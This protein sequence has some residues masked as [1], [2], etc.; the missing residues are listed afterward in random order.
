MEKVRDNYN[1][2]VQ[3]IKDIK[4]YGSSQIQAVREQYFEQVTTLSMYYIVNLLNFDPPPHP[5][6]RSSS[7]QM[8]RIRDYSSSQLDRVHENYIF[9]RQR[10]RKFSAQNYLRVRAT[11][12]STQ[13]TLN[14][15][16]EHLPPLYLDL[17]NCRQGMGG[18]QESMHFPDFQACEVYFFFPS[19][20]P[21]ST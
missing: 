11:G 17:S 20:D 15:V 16:I 13:R 19:S 4:Q 8:N 1:S 10:L 14:K 12:K 9:Q 3:N 6:P 7:L 21:L 18:R 2:Q 5:R